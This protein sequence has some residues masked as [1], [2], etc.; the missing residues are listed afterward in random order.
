[1]LSVLTD[2]I[3]IEL[4]FSIF[5][6]HVICCDETLRN[7]R[8]DMQIVDGTHRDNESLAFIYRLTCA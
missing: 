2:W 7:R 8:V 1:M 3:V 6:A 4:L 5:V